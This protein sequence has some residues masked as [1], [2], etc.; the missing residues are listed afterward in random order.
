MT[1]NQLF[2]NVPS[3]AELDVQGRL[4]IRGYIDAF[5]EATGYVPVGKLTQR[6]VLK[7]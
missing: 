5:S 7:I 4:W 3:Q 6:S 1:D 2:R